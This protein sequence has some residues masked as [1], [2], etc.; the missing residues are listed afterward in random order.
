MSAGQAY[1]PGIYMAPN[2]STS[3]GSFWFFNYHIEIHNFI[4]VTMI[5]SFFLRAFSYPFLWSSY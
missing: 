4:I 3:L 2:S 5:N 1:G